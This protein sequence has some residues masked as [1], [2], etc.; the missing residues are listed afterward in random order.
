MERTFPSTK[1]FERKKVH[2]ILQN[3]FDLLSRV[4][5]KQEPVK[6][7][8]MSSLKAVQVL[9]HQA[10]KWIDRVPFVR[11]LGGVWPFIKKEIELCQNIRE[12]SSH[13]D[14]VS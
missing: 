8:G 14:L 9:E 5:D 3:C 12:S 7:F 6:L 11:A 10:Q 2:T 4:E 13:Q 1:L